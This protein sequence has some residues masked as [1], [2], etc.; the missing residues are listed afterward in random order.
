MFQHDYA[1]VNGIKMHYVTAGSGDP[2]V[3]WHANFSGWYMWREIMAELSNRYRVIAFDLRG[4]NLT[5]I[6]DDPVTY[7][8]KMIVEDVR[9]F[10]EHLGLKQF[11]LV[12]SDNN[13]IPY[14]FASYYGQYLKKLVA[15]DMPHPTIMVRK[16]AKPTSQSKASRYVLE[17]QDPDAEKNFSAN[18][19]EKL[20]KFLMFTENVEEIDVND[21]YAKELIEVFSKPKA[22]TG[23]FNYY[24]ATSASALTGDKK[25]ERTTRDLMINVPTLVVASEQMPH[26]TPDLLDGLET[27]IPDV[28]IKRF[29]ELKLIT[30]EDPELLKSKLLPEFL[31]S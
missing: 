31:G 20:L 22:L 28:T 30:R 24:R 18:N 4:Y 26:L 7:Q 21:P 1:D 8:P 16:W 9:Q 29:P 2:V 27:L 3:F 25:N 17:F 15:I 12:A 5:S 19:F 6:P 10:V 14:V 11:H 23:A 13:G